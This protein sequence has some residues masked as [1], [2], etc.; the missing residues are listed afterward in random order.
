MVTSDFGF[1]DCRIN[2]DTGLREESKS[3]FHWE[4]GHCDVR[5]ES[6]C[7]T[8]CIKLY[9]GIPSC[10]RMSH[11][12]YE[13][14]FAEC[15]WLRIPQVLGGGRLCASDLNICFLYLQLIWRTLSRYISPY[16]NGL[17]SPHFPTSSPG[18]TEHFLAQFRLL[19]IVSL[20]GG[21]RCV[22]VELRGMKSR[23][24]PPSPQCTERNILSGLL[25]LQG[26]PW[27]GLCLRSSEV[28]LYS[29]FK[30]TIGP[31]LFSLLNCLFCFLPTRFPGL[32]LTTLF[33]MNYIPRRQGLQILAVHLIPACLISPKIQPPVGLCQ[34]TCLLSF[35]NMET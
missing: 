4:S 27:W 31:S 33:C 28:S 7:S 19:F 5:V 15:K 9:R 3:L 17:T 21:G 18:Q 14:K 35:P 25:A 29:I 6:R 16:L 30:K 8:S 23:W 24:R 26:C 20:L 10:L 32:P 1:Q 34:A 11:D 13:R 2:V 12:S 22:E